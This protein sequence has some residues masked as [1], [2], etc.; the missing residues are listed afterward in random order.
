[1][2][3][4]VTLLTIAGCSVMYCSCSCSC[5]VV[6]RISVVHLQL[7]CRGVLGLV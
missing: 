4:V 3:A 7:Y 6:Y 1:M 5:N 2:V